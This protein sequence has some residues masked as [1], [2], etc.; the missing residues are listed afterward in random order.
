LNATKVTDA[1]ARLLDVDHAAF[2]ALVLGAPAGA[3]GVVVVPYFDGERTPNRPDATGTIAGVRS[4]VTRAQ[5]ARAAVEGVVCGLLEAVDALAACDVDTD[6]DL[7]LVGG[8]ARSAAYRQVLADL[9]GRAVAV[10]RATEHVAAGACAQ[11]AAALHGCPPQEIAH[12]WQLGAATYVDPDQS[13]DHD[14][15]RSA[16]RAVAGGTVTT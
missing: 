13:V 4:D 14:A 15:I 7:V 8:G 11:A 12:Q 3:G 6:G 9:S 1:A 16:Y 10:P 2:D 5:L